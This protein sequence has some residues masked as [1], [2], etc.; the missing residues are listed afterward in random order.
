MLT[1]LERSIKRSVMATHVSIVDCIRT[2]SMQIRQN[3]TIRNTNSRKF[4]YVTKWSCLNAISN[5]RR[6][7]R[8]IVNIQ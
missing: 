2:I 5:P 7:V 1:E 4:I 3:A 6:G 8:D